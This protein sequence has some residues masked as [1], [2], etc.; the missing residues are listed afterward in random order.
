[1]PLSPW[2]RRLL[3]LLAVVAVLFGVLVVKRTAFLRQRM[4][5]LEVFVRTAWAVRA[6]ED[7]YTITDSH[8]FHYLYPPL[9]AILLVPLADPPPGVTAPWTLPFWG[10]AAIWY[11][12]NLACL[13]LAV[14]WLAGAL[15]RVG[16]PAGRELPRGGRRWWALRVLPAVAC[17]PAVGHTL[18]RGQVGLLLLLLLAGMAAATVRG[19][20]WRA[21]LWLAGAIC[22]KVIPAFLLLFPLWR[23]DWRGLAGCTLGLVLGLVVLPAAVLGP[24]RTAFYWREWTE[25]ML[26]P[27]MAQGE[28][29]SRAKELL[30]MT[31]TDSQ[32]FM[33]VLHNTLHADRASRPAE[34]DPWTRRLHWLLGACLT[35]ATLAAARRQPSREPCTAVLLL[36]ALTVLMILLSPVCHLHYFCLAIPLF[37]G[38]LAVAWERQADARAGRVL[39]GLL[40]LNVILHALPHVPGM[41]IVRDLGLA[42]YA[43][44]AVW[45]V[46][47]VVL[48]RR[49]HAPVAQEQ[50]T[51]GVRGAA[52]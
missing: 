46:G 1:M 35:V 34:P 12:F 13:A 32:S 8:G 18:M 28:D 37:M 25:V 24:A 21:G 51:R 5:D 10:T 27:A 3:Y 9:F 17:L 11:V 42:M 30:E 50:V 52:A 49:S 47:V 43:T 41:E 15:E 26:L 33:A 6:G 39:I 4:G 2:Q 45:A 36:G 29:K 31:A 44:L 19:R 14:H 16:N 23:R 20:R 7:I 38:L 22:L 48:W 40:G